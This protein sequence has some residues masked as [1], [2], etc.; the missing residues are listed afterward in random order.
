[1]TRRFFIPEVIQTSATDCGPATLK[2]LFAGFGM[3]LSYGRLREACQT[4]L[5]GTSIDTLE[6]IASTLGLDV[7]QR[8][9]PVDV[10]TRLTSSCVPAVV[11]MRLPDGAPHFVV[12]WRVHGPFVQ[13]MDPAAGR[14]WMPRRRFLESIYVHEQL[15]PASAWDEFS[16]SPA[17]TA[18]LEQRR[19]DLSVPPLGP[20][21]DRAHLDAAL[22]LAQILVDAGAL[23]RGTEAHEFLGICAENP[24]QIPAE[25][26]SARRIPSDP[27]HVVVRGAVLLTASGLRRSPSGSLPDSLEAVRR[28]PPPQIWRHIWSAVLA[29]GR[30]VPVAVACALV[31]AAATTVLEAVLFRGVLDVTRHLPMSGQRAA[32]FALIITFEMA[33]LVLEWSSVSGLLGLGRQLELGLRAG[34]LRKIP[35]LGDRYFQSRL[36]SDMAFRAHTLHLLRELPETVGRFVR[37]TATLC[38]TVAAIAWLSPGAAIAVAIAAAA[39]V[40]VPLLFHP[41]LVECELRVRET[42]AALSRFHLDGLQ[43]SRAIWAHAAESTMLAAQAPQVGR[44]ADAGLRQQSLLVVAEAFQM[45]LSC[46]P[47]IW[48]VLGHAARTQSAPSLMLLIYWA[49]SIPAVGRQLAFIVWAL[50]TLRNTVL[51]LLEPLGSPEEPLGDAEPVGSTLGVKV[52]IDDVTVVAAGHT[53]LDRV[54]LHVAPGEHVAIVGVSGAG[55]SSLVG[56]LLGWHQPIRGRVMVDGTTLDAA[57]LVQL[58]RDLAWVDPQ[59]HLFRSTLLDNLRYGNGEDSAARL[60]PVIG[61]AGLARVLHR[62]PDGLQSSLGDGGAMVS[63]GEGQRVRVGRAFARTG[64]RL[65][66]LDEPARGLDR[67]E[68]RSFLE[69]ARR[70]FERATLF[71]ITHDICDTLAFDRVLVIEGGRI[72]EQGAPRML[73]EREGSRYRALLEEER[74]VRRSVWVHSRWRRLRMSD[75]KLTEAESETREERAWMHA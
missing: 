61:D 8:M 51:R 62:L 31:A 6:T 64:V 10:V 12:L 48:L 26:W 73:R 67:D 63:G 72:V 23:R 28:E 15:A 66:V 37:L 16:A 29:H 40:G 71:A 24:A 27:D 56:L 33:V 3:Y 68:R 54:D 69:R 39:A 53:L 41:I 34:L 19:R 1:M 47:I 57:R 22:R 36:V 38:F 74:V 35:R 75:G 7:E 14:V 11:V 9:I 50:P 43:G 55:K 32:G 60:A 45:A 52:D 30:T 65:A 58:R 59:V 5:D 25:L 2:A 20:W 21:T 49:L 17:F 44:W 70:H 46:A 13:L 42:N 18:G 4:D